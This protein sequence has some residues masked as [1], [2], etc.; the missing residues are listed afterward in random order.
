MKAPLRKCVMHQSCYRLLFIL[1]TLSASCCGHGSD[2][3]EPLNSC[4]EDVLLKIEGFSDNDEISKSTVEEP[5]KIGNFA[6][7][8]SQQPAALFGFGG[9]IIDKSEIQLFFFADHFVGRKR[10]ITDLILGILFGVTDEFSVFLTTP[11]TPLLRDGCNRSRGLE[12]FFVQL[13][14]GFYNQKTCSYAD[15]ATLVGNITVPTGS[16]RKNPPTGFGSPS[17]FIGTTYYRTY[18]D[19]FLFTSDGA[20]LTTSDHRTKFGDQFLYQCGFGRNIPSPEGWIYAWLIEIDGQYNQKNRI[21]GHIDSNSGGNFIFVTPSV[22]VSSKEMVLQFGVSFP[23]NQNLFGKQN[24]IDYA[25]NFNF[26]WSF[27]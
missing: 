25:L 4:E 14:Y 5:P 24:K 12:D 7:P 27:Y 19:W 23:I 21:H 22:W 10:T 9:N 13:E 8:T 26:G 15:Q 1:Y 11:F 20:I 2:S 17:I 3:H 18:V 16:G 6:L